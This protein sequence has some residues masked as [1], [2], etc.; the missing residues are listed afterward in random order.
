MIP[1]L[2][3]E[4]GHLAGE[5]IELIAPERCGACGRVMDRGPVAGWC[6][7]CLERVALLDADRCGACGDALGP[8]GEC[9]RC[10]DGR[11]PWDRMWA[12]AEH[13]G[14][15][16]DLVGRW[17]YGPDPVLSRPL[18]ALLTAAAAGV[19]AVEPGT[20]V[21][22]VPQHPEA[23]RRRG[24]HPSGDLADAVVAQ[25]G[26]QRRTP[27]RRAR[28]GKPQVGLT[29]AERRR[30]VVRLF[31]IPARAGRCL[32]GRPVLLV[33]DVVTT[34]ATAA[35]CATALRA[36]GASPIMVLALARA[37]V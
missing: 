1:M 7:P 2:Q 33:D 32:V 9:L 5:L 30:N 26:G 37:T 11:R 31:G 15:M 16:R 27:L 22:P 25:L 23:W 12:V 20:C 19:V 21:V 8:A 28:G 3:A 18:G 17:K 36:A 13:T 29:A 4:I 14:V 6:D 10:R 24:F 34:T 35:A